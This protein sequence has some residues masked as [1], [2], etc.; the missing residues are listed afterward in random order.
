[1]VHPFATRDRVAQNRGMVDPAGKLAAQPAPGIAHYE[2]PLSERMR[3]FLRLEFLYQPMLR[4]SDTD[5]DCATRATLATLLEILAI[6]SRG[7]VRSE[8]LNELDHQI[9]ALE[10]FQSH[11]GVDGGRLDHLVKILIKSRDEISRIGT[12]FL[13]P[14]KDS[15]FL[16]AIKHRSAIPGGTCEFDL[17]EYSHWLRQPIVRRQEDMAKWIQP[18]RPLCKGVSEVLWLIRESAQSQEEKA[19]K[20][21]YQHSMQKDGNCRILRVSLPEGSP[22][23]PEISGSQ[24]RFTVRFLEWSTVESRAVQTAQDVAFKLSVC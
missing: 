10:R 2:Q 14:L 11:T 5:D 6:L 16:N 23:F 20:G 22:L 15:E 4:N 3:T 12:G 17:P 8:A 21:M 9:E 18:V 1:M 7:D 13:Q 19:I 24:H